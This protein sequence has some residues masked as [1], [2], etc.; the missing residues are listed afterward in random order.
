[1]RNTDICNIALGWLGANLILSMDDESV[2]AELCRT[3]YETSVRAAF[4]AVDWTFARAR[5]RIAPLAGEIVGTDYSYRFKLPT[6][7]LVVRWLS[8]DGSFRDVLSWSKE[9][10]I[11]YANKST[12]YVKYTRYVEDVNKYPSKFR[13]LIATQLAADICMPITSDQDQEAALR[14]KFE[15]LADQAS[16]ADGIQSQ[17][18]KARATTMTRARFR[19]V[20]PTG[21]IYG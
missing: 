10:D 8:H 12:L 13:H 19:S 9:E 7:C 1:M 5:V 20:G 18:Q 14:G 15:M 6:D 21:G 4:E 11:I 2:E 3:N 17:P 16:G